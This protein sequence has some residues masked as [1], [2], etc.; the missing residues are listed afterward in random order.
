MEKVKTVFERIENLLNQHTIHYQLKVHLPAHTSEESAF[1]RGEPLKIGA[2]ALV[3]KTDIGFMMAVLPADRKIDSSR[4]KQVL[5]TNNLRFASPEEL[6]ELTGLMSGAIPPFG[7]LFNILMI[8]DKAL[9]EEEYMAFNA[10]SLE[11]SIKMKTEDYRA[12]AKPKLEEFSIK[13]CL[14]SERYIKQGHF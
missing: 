13:K 14:S 7:S 6:L 11:K 10:G 12:I 5:N 8:V 3:M 9:L 4:L 1:H 2:K